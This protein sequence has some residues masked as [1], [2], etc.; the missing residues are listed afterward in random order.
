MFRRSSC[1]N[2]TP[3]LRQCGFQPSVGIAQRNTRPFHVLCS[4]ATN[5]LEFGP[6]LGILNF[7]QSFFLVTILSPSA[8]AVATLGEASSAYKVEADEE[9]MGLFSAWC[10]TNISILCV[11]T[12]CWLRCFPCERGQILPHVTL[13]WTYPSR[14]THLQNFDW[15]HLNHKCLLRNEKRI[16]WVVHHRTQLE[17]WICSAKNATFIIHSAFS[18]A[19]DQTTV[20]PDYHKMDKNRIP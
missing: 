10:T 4:E 20:V 12:P 3:R 16:R 17:S 7:G 9:F 19:I 2:I 13:E 5:A 8:H 18:A 11:K 1:Q 15:K 6:A 14:Q